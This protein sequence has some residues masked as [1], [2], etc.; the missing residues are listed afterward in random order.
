MTKTPPPADI[1]PALVAFRDGLLD[2]RDR[3]GT[4]HS[5]TLRLTIDALDTAITDPDNETA[6]NITWGNV[7]HFGRGWWA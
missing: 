7:Q 6:W 1:T 4:Q 5:E 2:L 3:L